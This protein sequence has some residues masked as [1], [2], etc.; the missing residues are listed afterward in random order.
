[1]QIHRSVLKTTLTLLVLPG[2]M[3][4]RVANSGHATPV[5]ASFCPHALAC[6]EDSRTM[7][8]YQNQQFSAQIGLLPKKQEDV[9]LDSVASHLG[10]CKSGSAGNP[11]ASHL[12]AGRATPRVD[13]YSN[14]G[15]H[16]KHAPVMVRGPRR[17]G[18][19]QQICAAR[20]SRMPVADGG[21]EEPNAFEGAHSVD[22]MRQL[23]GLRMTYKCIL[24]LTNKMTAAG[25]IG[26]LSR[27]CRLVERCWYIGAGQDVYRIP[28][29]VLHAGCPSF[30]AKPLVIC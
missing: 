10:H 1:M 4:E 23:L 11:V 21:H 13:A 24:I 9:I 14:A 30:L 8:R 19:H 12:R 16:R 15:L 7:P 18:C 2:A 22:T 25:R 5:N 17:E 3:V 28:G 20:Y 29:C 27:I 6:D 26:G